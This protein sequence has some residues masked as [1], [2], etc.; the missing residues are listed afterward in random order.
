MCI[1]KHLKSI[2]YFLMKTSGGFPSLV[3]E[4]PKRLPL[5]VGKPSNCDEQVT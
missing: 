2:L 1:I 3:L 4:I 5:K